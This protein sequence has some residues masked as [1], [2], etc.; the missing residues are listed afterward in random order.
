[1]RPAKYAVKT[2]A[3]AASGERQAAGGRS[4]RVRGHPPGEGARGRVPLPAGE[5]PA[6][7]IAWWWCGRSW[8]STRARRSSS[9]TRAASSTSPTTGRSRPRRSSSRPTTAATRRTCC[10]NSRAACGRCGPGGQP[11]ANWA[12]MVM[13]S[14]AW[15][16]K[17]WAA[18]MLP[19]EGRWQ[20]EASGGET[21]AA[22]DG[23]RHV[24]RA[25]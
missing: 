13:G 23:L 11:A 3:A 15:S 25:R 1:M 22:A 10:S 24:P 19:E 18:L 20:R 14:L 5:V 4:P 16:L 6:R 12:Y 21:E 8:R 17:A 2:A 7:R 9:T